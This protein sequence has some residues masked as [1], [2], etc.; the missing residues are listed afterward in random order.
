MPG[1]EVQHSFSKEG[2]YRARVSLYS[3]QGELLAESQVVNVIVQK[4]VIPSDSIVFEVQ[5]DEVFINEDVFFNVKLVEQNDNFRFRFFDG[6]NSAPGPWLDVPESINKYDK[7]D[8]YNAYAE[9]GRFDDDSVYSIGRSKTRQVI[10]NNRDFG[11]QLSA[12]T[13]AIS[14]GTV[15]LIADVFTNTGERDFLF[16]FDF[17]DGQR[18]DLQQENTTTHNYQSNNN[19]NAT[20][21]L[22]N[23]QGEVLAAA[24]VLIIVPPSNNI[25]I[26]I[27][28]ALGGLAGSSIAVKYLI[29][30]KLNLKPKTDLGKQSI[31]KEKEGLIDITVRINP[32]LNQSEISQSISKKILVEKVK[33]ST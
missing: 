19:Y 4:I 16:V 15:K 18:T 27:L 13:S 3:R 28:I 29:K 26:I 10:V 14:E 30:P 9:I 11:I 22:L 1:K 23:R 8:V 21:R 12:D 32:N 17:G 7:P 33:R 5:P 6:Q 25:L 24:S 20:V 31:S 2:T